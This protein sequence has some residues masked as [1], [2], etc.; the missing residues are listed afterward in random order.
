MPSRVAAVLFVRTFLVACH[1]QPAIPL[2]DAD[3]PAVNITATLPGAS[4]EMV[5]TSVAT[6]L[7]RQLSTIAGVRSITSSSR[8]GETS[9]TIQFEP[10]RDLDAA[11]SDVLAAIQKMLP[12]LPPGVTPLF[13][14]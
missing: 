14:K 7:E 8:R 5:A 10:K 4:P 11:A 12:Q 1:G 13:R 9:I 6:P 3:V 2:P